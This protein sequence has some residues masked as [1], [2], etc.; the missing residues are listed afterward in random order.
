M[1]KE[2]NQDPD[3]S[4]DY[5]YSRLKEH[6]QDY[7]QHL[8]PLQ[9]LVESQYQS[10]P[11]QILNEIRAF[12]DHIASCYY[13][14]ATEH[15]IQENIE[16]AESHLLRIKLD[17]YKFIIVYLHREY[18]KKFRK[19]EIF[20]DLNKIDNG[21]FVVQYY[22][23]RK[24]GEELVFQAKKLE[25]EDKDQALQTFEQA[26]N[27][28]FELKHLVESNRRGLYWTVSKSSFNLIFKLLGN[29]FAIVLT[30]FITFLLTKGQFNEFWQLVFDFLF[31]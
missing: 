9:A 2:S 26:M 19:F 28:Y 3:F 12:T 29:I 20:F 8:K 16:K 30:A 5:F 11:A 21:N 15:S 6:Y 31:K 27:K 18:V 4:N 17:C 22:H 14:S 13:T 10:V 1:D 25:S 24:E 7:L 23:I